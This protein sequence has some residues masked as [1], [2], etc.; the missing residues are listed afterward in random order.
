M[1]LMTVKQLQDNCKV[2]CTFTKSF[3]D[4]Y[5]KKGSSSASS[6]IRQPVSTTHTMIQYKYTV[7]YLTYEIF[8][9]T[10]TTNLIKQSSDNFQL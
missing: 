4:H 10:Y 3:N 2:K 6:L 9:E 7:K 8:L 5:L 1:L